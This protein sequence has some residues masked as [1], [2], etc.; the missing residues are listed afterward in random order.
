VA[1][2]HKVTDFLNRLIGRA[3]AGQYEDL[4]ENMQR[5]AQ[6]GDATLQGE[7]PLDTVQPI[8]HIQVPVGPARHRGAHLLTGRHR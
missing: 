5:L 4:L 8:P 3:P 2:E 7:A 6:Q 1:N